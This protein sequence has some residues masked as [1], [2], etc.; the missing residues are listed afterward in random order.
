MSEQ[1]RRGRPPKKA[2]EREETKPEV[3][4]AA[5]VVDEPAPEP[6]SPIVPSAPISVKPRNLTRESLTVS[7]GESRAKAMVKD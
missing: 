3:E 7:L 6:A 2:E 5:P 4:E 1:K